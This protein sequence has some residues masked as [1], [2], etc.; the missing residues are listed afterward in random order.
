MDQ[1]PTVKP[2]NTETARIEDE[3]S[4]GEDFFK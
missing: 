4:V 2:V 3:L 1:K